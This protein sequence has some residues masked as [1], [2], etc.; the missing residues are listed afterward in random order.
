[1]FVCVRFVVVDVVLFVIRMLI[2]V[3]FFC[4]WLNSCFVGM[5]KGLCIARVRLWLLIAADVCCCLVLFVVMLVVCVVLLLVL[6]VCAGW[7]TARV[8]LILIAFALC[9][10][11]C[12]LLL[13]V[14]AFAV[15]LLCC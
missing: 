8:I 6:L 4:A 12:F 15:L 10:C 11:V 5:L 14:Y 13:V 3:W 2:V 9:S 7:L 1:M